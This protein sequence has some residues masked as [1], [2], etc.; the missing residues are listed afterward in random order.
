MHQGEY[1]RLA[2]MPRGIQTLRRKCTGGYDAVSLAAIG[3][4]HLATRF[5]RRSFCA[6]GTERNERVFVTARRYSFMSGHPEKLFTGIFRNITPALSN[7]E[8]FLYRLYQ[9]ARQ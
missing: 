7:K 8:R 6:C 4:F 5:A 1:S 9:A 3:N 2:G